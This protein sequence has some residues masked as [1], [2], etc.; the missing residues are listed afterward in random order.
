MTI[1]PWHLH[2][3]NIVKNLQDEM[4]KTMVV[5]DGTKVFKPI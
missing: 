1:H 2:V 4:V 5:L 3:Q